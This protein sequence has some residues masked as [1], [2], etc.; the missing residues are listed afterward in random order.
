[1]DS[2]VVI[3]RPS[4]VKVVLVHG[5]TTPV[6]VEPSRTTS[7]TIQRSGIAGPK[8]DKGEP[9]A[10]GQLIIDTN[11]PEILDGGFA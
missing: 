9:G 1:M 10:P 4:G 6:I 5:K 7:V 11:V 3:L 8:G 2:P